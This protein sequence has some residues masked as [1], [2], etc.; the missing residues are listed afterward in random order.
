MRNVAVLVLLALMCLPAPA[1]AQDVT[2]TN[3]MKESPSADDIIKALEPSALTRSLR[4]TDASSEFGEVQK[5]ELKSVALNITFGFDSAVLTASARDTLDQLGM[6][7]GS[8]QLDAYKFLVE[9][10]T[11]AKGSETYTQSLSERRAYAVRDYLA[12]R[13]QIGLAKLFVVGKGESSPLVEGD[14]THGDNRRVEIVN[15]GN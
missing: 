7:L 10:H 12:D 8:A 11:D 5:D 1:S 9:G 13:H 6:A 3:F 4:R 2:T 15:L 14:P